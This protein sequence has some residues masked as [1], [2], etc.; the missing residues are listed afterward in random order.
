MALPLGRII[1]PASAENRIQPA[2][3][4]FV[5]IDKIGG[6]LAGRIFRQPQ[7]SCAIRR[8]YSFNAL[9]KK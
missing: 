9:L 6:R 3:A 1:P 5:N 7:P 8:R 2:A 4:T